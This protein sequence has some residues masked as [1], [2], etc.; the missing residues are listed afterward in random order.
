MKGLIAV[1]ISS[2]IMMPALYA[3]SYRDPTQPPKTGKTVA[4]TQVN[5]A[6]SA[7]IYG[8]HRKLAYLNGKY[9]KVG[10]TFDNAR[11]IKIERHRI[12]LETDDKTFS[13]NVPGLTNVKTIHKETT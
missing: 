10:D 13:I 4:T 12:L 3:Q 7:I 11:I 8:K 1:C 9:Y 6:T 5:S 2:I